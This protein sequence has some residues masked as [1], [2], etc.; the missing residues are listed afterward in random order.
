MHVDNVSKPTLYLV[1]L[2]FFLYKIALIPNDVL[3][4]SIVYCKI[5]LYYKQLSQI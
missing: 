3:P 1:I 4:V 2:L 5:Y